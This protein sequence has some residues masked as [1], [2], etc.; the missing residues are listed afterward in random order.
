MV[1]SLC[2][3]DAARAQVQEY[4]HGLEPLCSPDRVPGCSNGCALA[5]PL[6]R[7]CGP[8]QSARTGLPDCCARTAS[9]PIVTVPGSGAHSLRGHSDLH[10]VTT[11]SAR[12]VAL[13]CAGR[14]NPVPW[15][16]TALLQTCPSIRRMGASRPGASAR[17][18]RPLA[19]LAH[20]L[21]LRGAGFIRRRRRS[22]SR[23]PA[24]RRE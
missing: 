21:G 6:G 3:T 5:R 16:A 9:G 22:P 23:V 20:Q 15:R 18:C 8:R 1:S 14:A 2:P 10:R 11:P 4:R 24:E 7:G 13:V 19:R 17:G 12:P